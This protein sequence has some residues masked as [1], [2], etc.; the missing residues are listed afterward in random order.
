MSIKQKTIL[1][2]DDDQDILN[3]LNKILKGAGFTVHLALSPEEARKIIAEEPPHLIISDLNMEP[4]HGYSFIQKLRSQKQFQSIPVIVLSAV[5]D[6]NSVKKVVALGISDYVIKP[7]Q[8]QLLLRKIRKTLLHKEFAVWKAPRGQEPV[9][10]I[11]F[12]SE[13]IELG[14]TGYT[15]SGPFKIAP[16]E[17]LKIQVAEFKGLGLDSLKQKISPMMKTY[18]SGGYFSNDVTFIAISE[19]ASAKIRQY[20]KKCT[21]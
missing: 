16:G 3:I 13:I 21:E 14:E 9:V 20:I 2:V 18:L 19:D 4:E 12:E 11:H 8:G 1:V 10:T 15:L 5:N 7:I 17:E 6:F